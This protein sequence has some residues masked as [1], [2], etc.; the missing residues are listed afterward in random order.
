LAGVL[1]LQETLE[2]LSGPEAEPSVH[3][4]VPSAVSPE[5][6]IALVVF[7]VA[8]AMVASAAA[9]RSVASPAAIHS[10]A[11]LVAVMPAGSQVAAISGAFPAVEVMAGAADNQRNQV[12]PKRI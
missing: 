7:Q 12:F 10:V 8:I 11:F 4:T 1:D 6:A 3:P 9:V 5:G 2:G